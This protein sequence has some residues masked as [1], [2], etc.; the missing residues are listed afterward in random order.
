MRSVS[1]AV[2]ALTADAQGIQTFTYL[3]QLIL[4]QQQRKN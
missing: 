1:S 4:K 2:A 3:V